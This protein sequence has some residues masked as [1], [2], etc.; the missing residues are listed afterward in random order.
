MSVP[1]PGNRSTSDA[2]NSA[3][4]YIIS[5]FKSQAQEF[6]W[7]LTCFRE[8]L[9]QY[10]AHNTQYMLLIVGLAAGM[11]FLINVTDH[12]YVFPEV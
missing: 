2:L 12:N 10:L 9:G 5:L 4:K 7:E 11:P 3:H 1:G 6:P 8:N